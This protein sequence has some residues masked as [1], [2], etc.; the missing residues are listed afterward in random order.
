MTDPIDVYVDQ[1]QVS[2]GPYGSTLNFLISEPTPP[3]PGSSPKNE[4]LATIRM[5]LEHLKAMIFV[6]RNQVKLHERQTGTTIQ[7]PIQVLNSLG[8]SPEDWDSFW[9]KD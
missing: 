4:R 9:R 3:A 5:S 7:L 2:T 8:I 1:F 6:L